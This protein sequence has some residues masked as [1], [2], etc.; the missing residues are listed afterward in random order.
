MTMIEPP[1]F[2]GADDVGA[3]LIGI[4]EKGSVTLNL[5]YVLN[6]TFEVIDYHFK[7]NRVLGTSGHSAFPPEHTAIGI[8]SE[9]ITRLENNPHPACL[10]DVSGIIDSLGRES[11]LPMKI[12]YS[13]LWL[14][15]DLVIKVLN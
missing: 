11:T 4:I 1:F 9:A 10:E 13:N 2:P 5:T 3:G 12:L 8:L 6:W 7:I 15:E 14:F